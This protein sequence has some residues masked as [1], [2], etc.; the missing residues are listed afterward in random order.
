MFVDASG[1]YIEAET[2]NGKDRKEGLNLLARRFQVRQ[3]IQGVAVTSVAGGF[4]EALDT[5]V[6][7]VGDFFHSFV[8]NGKGGI[9]T[10]K[11]IP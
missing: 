6:P 3:T 9:Y 5:P 2:C 7:L 10:E 1:A 11:D 4:E 8:K